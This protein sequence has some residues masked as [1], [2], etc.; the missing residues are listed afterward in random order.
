MIT[1]VLFSPG[2]FMI[3]WFL[4]MNSLLGNRL[5]PA[6]QVQHCAVFSPPAESRKAWRRIVDLP[7]K[8][9][10]VLKALQVRCF[11]KIQLMLYTSSNSL[12]RSFGKGREKKK[13][14]MLLSMFQ[15]CI[16]STVR[17]CASMTAT[18]QAAN[19]Y[20]SV[21]RYNQHL[22]CWG[23]TTYTGGFCTYRHF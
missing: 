18:T 4:Q 3:L 2:H 22:A 17:P 20:C 6:H 19:F 11:S 12:N 8:E 5:F 7:K 23:G 15:E 21:M 16:S 9:P 13:N 14:H 10:L 1:V